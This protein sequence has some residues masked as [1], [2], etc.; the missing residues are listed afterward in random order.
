MSSTEHGTLIS[1]SLVSSYS[2]KNVVENCHVY[3]YSYFRKEKIFRSNDNK[4]SLN[5]NMRK[6]VPHST[7]QNYGLVG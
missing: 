7:E 2:C 1:I 5:G 3:R 4:I 6:S